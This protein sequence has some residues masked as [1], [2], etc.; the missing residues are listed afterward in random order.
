MNFEQY[1]D[2]LIDTATSLLSIDSASGF[3]SN[4]A[5]YLLK[6]IEELGY[7]VCTRRYIGTYGPLYYI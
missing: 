1:Q 6:T 7:P 3:T 4:V 2:Y 5:D